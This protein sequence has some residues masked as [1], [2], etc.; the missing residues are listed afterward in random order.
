MAALLRSIDAA[1]LFIVRVLRG[2]ADPAAISS[3]PS[4]CGYGDRA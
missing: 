4:L 2:R 3:A 1:N